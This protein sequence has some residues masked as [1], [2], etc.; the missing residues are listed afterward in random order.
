MNRKINKFHGIVVF[1]APGSGKT[2]VAKSFLKIFPEAKYVEASSSVIYPAIS[3]KEELPPRE[4][5][6][7]RAI[8]KLRHKRKF[9]RDEAQQMFVYLKNK[10][11][12]A[13]IAKTL[14]YLHR[15]KFFHKS[16]II[17]GI[18]GFRNSMYFK[19]NGYL[20]VYLKT[21]DKYLTGRISRRE[22]FSKKDAEKERQIE[23]RL[24]STNKVERIA[25]LTFN[26]AVTSKKE[27]AAQIKALIG[28]AECKKCVNTSSNLSSV[29]GKYGL[30]DVCEKYEKNF[31]GAVLQ[32]ELRF[33]LSL[34]GSGKEKHD[35]MVGISGGKD[36]TATLYTA[37]QMGFIPL[38]FSLDTGYYP[39]HIF[40]RAKTVAKKLKVDYEKIDARIY[41]R[42]VDRICF[43]KTS[44]LYNERDSQELKEKFRKW[45]VEGRRHYSVKCQH[46]IPFVRTCQLCRRLVVRAYYGEALKRGVKVVILGINEW[47]GLSQDSESKKFIFSAIRK[48]QPFKNKPPVYIVHLP[49]LLQ[50]KIEDTE[51]ILRKLGWKI[52]RGERLIESNANSCLFAR[53][54]ES[55]AKRMLGFHPDTTRLAREVTVGFISKEQAS[56]ALA[57]VHNY[58]HSVRRVLQKAKVL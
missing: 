38:T 1:G 55:K 40:Q 50:R 12:S 16:L 7:I 4:T 51:R 39:K 31:S 36:S 41:M 47:A 22:S 57:K 24:F 34:R 45:Y 52:P 37:K 28:A 20:V 23:E 48:L 6:F 49:F 2:T 26:T 14:I 3:I 32:K 30:C 43:R 5:D 25:H 11:S 27:I 13:V 10:Y 33:L 29:I 46:K 8:L 15:K 53:A 18:R 35:A 19:K 58:P 42:S 56:S 54:A 17:A 21:P 44:D 9:S